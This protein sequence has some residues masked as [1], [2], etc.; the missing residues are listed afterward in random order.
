MVDTGAWHSALSSTFARSL[1]VPISSRQVRLVGLGSATVPLTQYIPIF[2]ADHV[3]HVTFAVIPNYFTNVLLGLNDF[4]SLFFANV[5]IPLFLSDSPPGTHAAVKDLT[6]G[7]D[8]TASDL[9]LIADHRRDLF[10]NFGHPNGAFFDAVWDVFLQYRD[11]W[12]RPSIGLY[13]GPPAH[14]IPVAPPYRA[15]RRYMAPDSK[16]ELSKHLRSQLEQ[17]VIRRSKS[18]WG[19]PVHFVMKKDGSKRL[20]VD[21]RQLNDRIVRDS[22]PLPRTQEILADAAGHRYVITLDLSWGFWNLPLTEESKPLTAFVTHEGLFESNVL[23]FGLANSPSEFQRMSDS[24]WGHLFHLGVRVYIDDIV[25]FDNDFRQLLHTLVLVLQA[26]QRAKVFFKLKK[27][28]VLQLETQLLGFLVSVGG[29]RPIPERVTA[30]RKLGVPTSL[31]SLRSFLGATNFFARHVPNLS[32]LSAPMRP[33]L[34]KGVP[35]EWSTEMDAAYYEILKALEQAVPLMPP[36]AQTPYLV[37]TDASAIGIGACI[38]QQYPDGVQYPVCF[39]SKLLDSTQRAWDAREREAFAIKYTLETFADMLRGQEII[40]YTDNSSLT[41]FKDAPQ[42]KIQRWRWY[43]QQFRPLL[44]HIDGSLNNTADWLSRCPP[45]DPT[46]DDFIDAIALPIPHAPACLKPL[47]ASNT[48][49]SIPTMSQLKDAYPLAS[50]EELRL[51]FVGVDD[52][53]FSVK[54]NRLFIPPPF[55]ETILYLV[56]AGPYAMHRGGHSDVATTSEVCLVVWSCSRCRA[57]R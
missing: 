36:I 23:P 56:H 26:A 41:W 7:I 52:L 31:T 16:D 33:L 35:F 46:A 15:P 39:L 12:L 38:L 13:T 37:F 8:N 42:A 11:C 32:V 27:C 17:G 5:P 4:L 1:Q 21:Y 44:V 55:R 29:I 28:T 57:F 50:P 54:T 48:K 20:V 34:R 51:T 45:D 3:L 14:I 18:A 47:P 19:A 9:T 10:K 30:L 53:R 6:T 40:I 49:L 24:I 43:I 25:I 2:I 22:Y